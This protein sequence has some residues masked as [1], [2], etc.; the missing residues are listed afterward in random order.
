MPTQ[1]IGRSRS[2]STRDVRRCRANDLPRRRD[3][4]CDHGR[5]AGQSEAENKIA[6]IG[7]VFETDVREDQMRIEPGMLR[8]EGRQQ[9]SDVLSAKIGGGSNPE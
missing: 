8:G 9:G 3:L 4:S 7:F 2:A 1:F 6:T 5:I